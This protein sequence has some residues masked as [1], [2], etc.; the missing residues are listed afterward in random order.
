MK[1]N[2]MSDKYFLEQAKAFLESHGTVKLS[3][4]N[5]YALLV[6]NPNNPVMFEVGLYEEDYEGKLGNK[7]MIATRIPRP[8]RGKASKFL[9]W[10]TLSDLQTLRRFYGQFY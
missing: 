2:K 8:R 7:V 3:F 6:D 4:G 5:G 9:T 1:H 10:L